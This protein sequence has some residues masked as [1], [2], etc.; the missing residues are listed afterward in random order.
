MTFNFYGTLIVN[1]K[2]IVAA[3]AGR[4][5][6]ESEWTPISIETQVPRGVWTREI[7][8]L[9]RALAAQQ[10]AHGPSTDAEEK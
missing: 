3:P 9:C 6:V 10:R 1:P 5:E 4:A 2:T 8:E 7:E